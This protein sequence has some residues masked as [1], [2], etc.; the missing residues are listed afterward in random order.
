MCAVL[1]QPKK[2]DVIIRRTSISCKAFILT[3]EKKPTANKPIWAYSRLIFSFVHTQSSSSRIGSASPPTIGVIKYPS[4]RKCH[5]SL[6]GFLC[7]RRYLLHQP[8]CPLLIHHKRHDLICIRKIQTHARILPEQTFRPQKIHR[9]SAYWTS[10]S[11]TP[12]IRNPF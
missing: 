8:L 1:S 11:I 6:D 10:R 9:P 4:K 7:P 2:A 3:Q 12:F 5:F